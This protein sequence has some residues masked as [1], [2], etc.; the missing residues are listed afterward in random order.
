MSCLQLQEFRKLMHQYLEQEK[1]TGQHPFELSC[2]PIRG[3]GWMDDILFCWGD[4]QN[5]NFWMHQKLMPRTFCKTK[6][7]LGSLGQSH[8]A[9]WASCICASKSFCKDVG[10]GQS[11]VEM[12]S[13]STKDCRCFGYCEYSM[14]PVVFLSGWLRVLG[15][16]PWQYLTVVHRWMMKCLESLACWSCPNTNLKP[17]KF[18]PKATKANHQNISNSISQKQECMWNITKTSP[19]K[20]Q[21]EVFLAFLR[22]TQAQRLSAQERAAQKAQAARRAS[23]NGTERAREAGCWVGRWEEITNIPKE[24]M[25]KRLYLSWRILCFYIF[26]YFMIM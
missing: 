5:T 10:G 22:W 19:K 26:W 13:C 18:L 4:I 12:Q 21:T 9:S 15:I 11:P 1:N 7:M 6:T 2:E 8:Q 16:G 23:M 14:I 3:D 25:E 17:Q 20:T 24:D